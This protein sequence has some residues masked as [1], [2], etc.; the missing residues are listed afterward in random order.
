MSILVG[1]PW[2]RQLRI[3][4]S[5]LRSE[6]IILINKLK[7]DNGASKLVEKSLICNWKVLVERGKCHSDLMNSN[8]C[9][10]MS[11]DLEIKKLLTYI[12]NY[13]TGGSR[14]WG[15]GI[16]EHILVYLYISTRYLG[17]N[18]TAILEPEPFTRYHKN[19]TS[20]LFFLLSAIFSFSVS[21]YHHLS[22]GANL[23]VIYAIFFIWRFLQI[24][25]ENDSGLLLR[26][27]SRKWG[28]DFAE[29]S[30]LDTSIPQYLVAQ[31]SPSLP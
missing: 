14:K 24:T 15:L 19:F 5:K 16:K 28:H 26:L 3:R 25:R 11:S 21:L 20:V 22:R 2:L 6:C 12:L 31:C 1:M 4:K 27:F 13:T 29:P 8:N 10:Y 30:R 7:I 18:S 23:K 9:N 17:L